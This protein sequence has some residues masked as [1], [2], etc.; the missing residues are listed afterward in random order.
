MQIIIEFDFSQK[1]LMGEKQEIYVNEGTTLRECMI[2][3]DTL[4]ENTCKKKDVSA[5]QL[6]ILN[7]NGSLNSCIVAVNGQTP[8]EML[9]YKLQNNDSISLIYG[10]CGG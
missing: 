10:Y 8:S 1:D 6:R 9:D 7:K 2:Y 5:D 4:I 3:V